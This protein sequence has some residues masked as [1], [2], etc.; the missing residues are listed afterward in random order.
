MSGALAA[1]ESKKCVLTSEKCSRSIVCLERQ[2]LLWARQLPET[3]FLIY[4]FFFFLNGKLL[5]YTLSNNKKEL[6]FLLQFMQPNVHFSSFLGRRECDIC[7]FGGELQKVDGKVYIFPLK[8]LALCPKCCIPPG[9]IG[10]N[11]PEEVCSDPGH[12]IQSH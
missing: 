3:M 2:L 11:C 7:Y 12:G 1:M 4:Q 6:N 8:R 5:M 9:Y 10:A